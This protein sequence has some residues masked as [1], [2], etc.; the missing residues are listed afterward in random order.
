MIKI[1]GNTYKEY[2]SFYTT[3]NYYL[4][5][6]YNVLSI[7]DTDEKKE[8]VIWIISVFIKLINYFFA[9]QPPE[10]KFTIEARKSFRANIFFTKIANNQEKLSDEVKREIISSFKTLKISEKIVSGDTSFVNIDD[11]ISS[12]F[13]KKVNEMRKN[14]RDKITPEQALKKLK[15]IY[16]EA[17]YDRENLMKNF[18]ETGEFI[19]M[20]Y[21]SIENFLN[22][23]KTYKILGDQNIITKHL[24]PVYEAYL[25][26]SFHSSDDIS[27]YE[28]IINCY[29]QRDEMLNNVKEMLADMSNKKFV[30]IISITHSKNI[31]KMKEIIS[32]LNYID[33]P[34]YVIYDTSII[35]NTE[36]KEIEDFINDLAEKIQSVSIKIKKDDIWELESFRVL[37]FLSA[38]W[39]RYIY[40]REKNDT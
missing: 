28:N 7:F 13:T 30:S 39:F 3:F 25:I 24:K 40:H 1:V 27:N 21:K 6:N 23:E 2:D 35:S 17:G 10:D 20:D 4:A 16:D 22:D 36:L 26:S 11:I 5:N 8:Q 29:H 15:E 37:V 33:Y 34:Y 18:V 38:M 12:F 31:E 19:F 32:D 9:L 14:Y